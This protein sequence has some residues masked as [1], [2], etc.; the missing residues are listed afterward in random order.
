MSSTKMMTLPAANVPKAL[1]EGVCAALAAHGLSLTPDMLDEIVQSAA[2]S[3]LAIDESLVAAAEPTMARQDV[4]LEPLIVDPRRSLL[5]LL[6]RGPA[7]AGDPVSQNLIPVER[8]N[9]TP[10]RN[11]SQWVIYRL[12]RDGKLPHVKIGRRR[13]LT[14]DGITAFMAAGG[15]HGHE[16]QVKAEI[17]KLTAALPQSRCAADREFLDDG[18]RG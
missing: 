3:L 11:L 7:Q 4:E 14:A 1:N 13:Y 17:R 16:R 10:L 12:C 15:E 6:Q 18:R 9:E 2:K 8:K 5:R